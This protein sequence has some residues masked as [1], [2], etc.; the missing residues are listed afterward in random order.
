MES[1]DNKD[2][3]LYGCRFIGI[4]PVDQLKIQIYEI[5]NS[6]DSE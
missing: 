3:I 2:E 6:K 1:S 4:K 5:I